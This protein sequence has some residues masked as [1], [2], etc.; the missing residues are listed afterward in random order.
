MS[1]HIY[2]LASK[3]NGTLYVG[4]CANPAERIAQH[5]MG[6]GS[7]F[8]WKYKVFDLVYL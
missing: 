6:K 7:E 4:S 2:I 3:R 8:V 1:A 5:R